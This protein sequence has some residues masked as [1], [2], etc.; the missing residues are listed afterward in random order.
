MVPGRGEVLEQVEHICNSV[1]VSRSAKQ[2]ALLRYIVD[3]AL[4]GEESAL[5]EQPLGVDFFELPSS[6]DPRD[7]STVRTAMKKL[8][9]GLDAYRDSNISRVEILLERGSYVP[10][11]L[12]SGKVVNGRRA[13][14]RSGDRRNV[15]DRRSGGDR[16]INDVSNPT[17]QPRALGFGQRIRAAARIL[18]G[19]IP[20]PEVIAEDTVGSFGPRNKPIDR[21]KE[22]ENS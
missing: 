6:W 16:R 21:K 14:R 10:R 13:D 1:P 4:D 22:T 3:K 20:A 2:Q 5:R 7:V 18:L 11:F 17:E 12:Y 9:E 15:D 19:R 8:R